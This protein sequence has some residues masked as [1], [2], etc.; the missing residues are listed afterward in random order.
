MSWVAVAVAGAAVVGAV[1]QNSAANK[2]AKAQKGAANAAI[3]HTE[4]NYDRTKSDLQPYITLGGNAVGTLNALNSGDASA[5]HADPGYQFAFDQGLQGLD[6]SA[7]ARG[8]LYSGGHSADL[9]RYGQGMADQQ[10]GQ[11]YSRLMGLAGLGQ[12]AASNLGSVGNGAAASIGGY[13]Q[14]SGNAQANA[15]MQQGQNWSNLA[16]DLGSAFAMYQGAHPST[17]SSYSLGG[18]GASTYQGYNTGTLNN[19]TFD[20]TSASGGSY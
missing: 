10:Y 19:G 15:A 14:N 20:F 2:A 3:A 1:S 4:Q 12:N 8:S 18:N 16:G 11:F 17:S 9:I 5:F 7:A 6:R 13:L